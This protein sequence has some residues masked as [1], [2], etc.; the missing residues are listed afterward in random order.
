MEW[1][2][3]ESF[4]TQATMYD[5]WGHCGGS[6]CGA[7]MIF[8]IHRLV[9]W[10]RF[11]FRI[12]TDSLSRVFKS[13]DL[14]AAMNRAAWRST[15]IAFAL[16]IGLEFYQRVFSIPDVIANLIGLSIFMLAVWRRR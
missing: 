4:L 9:F 16:G 6:C 2:I 8:I 3:W 10:L 5:K 15:G 1:I 13:A 14:R 11:H 7:A 12:P